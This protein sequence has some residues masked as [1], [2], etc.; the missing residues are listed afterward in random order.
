MKWTLFDKG[1]LSTTLLGNHI[2]FYI[3]TYWHLTIIIKKRVTNA[4]IQGLFK[5]KIAID[6]Y[7]VGFVG[8]LHV[9]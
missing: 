2:S 6:N 7:L 5:C 1:L 8:N 4:D 9:N 3:Q